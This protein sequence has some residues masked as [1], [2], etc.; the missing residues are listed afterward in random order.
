[1]AIAVSMPSTNLLFHVI[2]VSS[3]GFRCAVLALAAM[4]GR[5]VSEVNGWGVVAGKIPDTHRGWAVKGVKRRKGVGMKNED[6]G[7]ECNRGSC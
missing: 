1:M 3:F 2:F 5:I 6:S 7:C 4:L